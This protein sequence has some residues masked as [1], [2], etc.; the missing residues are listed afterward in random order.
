MLGLTI[1]PDTDLTGDGIARGLAH[2]VVEKT[3]RQDNI[4]DTQ[5]GGEGGAPLVGTGWI[6]EQSQECCEKA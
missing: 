4:S 2:C 1:C 3:G 5:G 6:C